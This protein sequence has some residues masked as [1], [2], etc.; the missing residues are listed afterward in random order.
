[1]IETAFLSL[2]AMQT[3]IAESVDSGTFFRCSFDAVADGTET[4]L[5]FIADTVSGSSTKVDYSDPSKVIGGAPFERIEGD[6]AA[7]VGARQFVI[8]PNQEGD[9]N[10][11]LT[12]GSAKEPI[13][14]RDRFEVLVAMLGL[15]S[16]GNPTHQGQCLM[17]QGPVRPV[18]ERLT[19][20]AGGRQ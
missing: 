10:W 17:M 4:E 6:L 7:D 8:T 20:N 2:L 12:L 5:Y 14:F 15:T 9:A 16:A 18:F 3:P 19:R 1:M 11:L 13:M